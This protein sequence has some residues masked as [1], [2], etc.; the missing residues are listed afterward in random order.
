LLIPNFVGDFDGDG[1]NDLAVVD[2]GAGAD[3][4]ILLH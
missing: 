2:G 4:V 3:R 1:F